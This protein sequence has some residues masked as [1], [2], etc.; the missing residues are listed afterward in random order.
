MMKIFYQ[1]FFMVILG[2]ASL[3]AHSSAS[4]K[5]PA[6][7]DQFSEA[8]KSVISRFLS[9][10]L[11]KPITENQEQVA[12]ESTL[13]KLYG[14]YI[15]K[16]KNQ[17]TTAFS[18]K[19]HPTPNSSLP[20][21]QNKALAL[22]DLKASLHTLKCKPMT[23][24]SQKPSPNVILITAKDICTQGFVIRKPGHYRLDTKNGILRWNPSRAA[25]MITIDADN[26][27]LDLNQTTVIQN[28]QSPF[29]STAIN[30]L[31]GHKNITVHNGALV[32][33]TAE[34]I[35]AIGINELFIENMLITDNNNR[36]AYAPIANLS[37]IHI[38]NC[39]NVI[40][41]NIAIARTTVNSP[42]DLFSM[43]IFVFETSTFLLENCHISEVELMA[44]SAVN[45]QCSGIVT[46]LSENGAISNCNVSNCT[47]SGVM[48]GF[49]YV[50]AQNVQSENCFSNDNT[51]VQTT[52]GFYPQ[53]SD[54][55]Q[56]INCEANN[57]QST[58]QD[59]HGFPYFVSSNGLFSNCRAINN[60]AGTS[61]GGFCEK[62]TGFEIFLCVHCV[63]E[64]CIASRN[65]ARNPIRH[66]AAGFANGTAL[67][68]VF[69]NCI[70]SSNTG[71]G[72]DSRG[73][74]FGPALAPR[75]FLPSSGTI[76][77]NCIAEG[78]FGDTLCIG[79]DLFGQQNSILIGSKSLNHGFF[80]LNPGIGIFSGF[81]YDSG[82]PV[83]ITCN[84]V[85]IV[86]T[87]PNDEL[88]NIVKDNVV[89]G[90]STIGI[91]DHTNA[92]NVYIDNVAFNNNIN[93]SGAIFDTPG[94]PVR[95]WTVPSAPSD[96]NNNGV[97]GDKLDNLD[98]RR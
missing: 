78:N 55:L 44:T 2:G 43:G 59:C 60:R 33:F 37:S 12:D 13:K 8:Q 41:R 84:V 96:A 3:S 53:G 46:L 97:V 7:L 80:L 62:A 56:F 30:I 32:G 63:L 28:P 27:I 21:K 52:A 5:D 54:S 67:D 6:F 22:D 16:W 68:T 74:G 94:T 95:D 23:H 36:N 57:N 75:L 9:Q 82:N 88:H 25:S 20:I 58:C 66:Y 76:W 64:N 71:V 10:E 47:S 69:R 40:V 39:L 87:T 92:N 91:Y 29:A 42:H 86:V 81:D 11:G 19:K 38:Q 34:T 61:S 4:P 83:D 89:T 26:V 93:Y 79:F 1:I 77:E 73:V 18:L 35:G 98:I 15:K 72:N 14:E 17:F 49:S 31:S 24:C 90:N 85:P 51:G 65:T 48:P 45:S 50:G 70:S